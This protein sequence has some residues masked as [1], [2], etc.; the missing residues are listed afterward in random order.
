MNDRST[1]NVTRAEWSG[2]SAAD[3]QTE[4]RKV[5]AMLLLYTALIFFA[6]VGVTMLDL[7][8]EK[9]QESLTVGGTT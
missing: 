7:H 5:L 4:D 2:L 6:I 1:I 9:P 3:L 8:L